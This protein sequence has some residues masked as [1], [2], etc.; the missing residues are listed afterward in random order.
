MEIFEIKKIILGIA[1]L[2]VVFTEIF[3]PIHSVRAED[4]GTSLEYTVLAP[5]PGTADCVG[6]ECK[7]TLQKY[8]PGI[9]KLAVA[10]SAIFAVLMI[11]IGGFQY[12]STDA[13]QKKSEGKERIKNA[14]FGLILVISSWLILNTINPDLLNLRLN[15]KSVS[16]SPTTNGEQSGTLLEV[17][18]SAVDSLKE[19]CPN[20]VS[21]TSTTGGQHS[22]NS[23]HYKGLAVDIASNTNLTQYLTG[24]VSNPQPCTRISKNLDG[25]NATFLWEPKGTTCGTVQSDGDHWHMSVNQ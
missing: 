2:F 3:V 15:I 24:S 21:I 18:Q 9:F 17:T 23:A 10:I 25:I 12:I 19:A 20:C 16:T 14:I 6:I 5:L 7:T 11:V 1:I 13:I 22:V 4:T 8:L